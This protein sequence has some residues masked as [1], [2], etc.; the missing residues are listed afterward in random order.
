MRENILTFGFLY[1]IYSYL[2]GCR[3]KYF[4]TGVLEN[5]TKT[6]LQITPKSHQT[7]NWSEG[8]FIFNIVLFILD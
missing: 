3:A 8:V 4:D 5:P 7:D 2:N 6:N 1:M